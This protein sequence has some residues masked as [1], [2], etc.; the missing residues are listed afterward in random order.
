MDLILKFLEDDNPYYMFHW[1]YKELIEYT[2]EDASVI[3]SQILA[4]MDFLPQKEGHSQDVAGVIKKDEPI[5]FVIEYVKQENELPILVD[6]T[7][8]ELD[9]YLDYI[10][11]KKSI[12]SYIN[13][14]TTADNIRNSVLE[15]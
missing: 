6:L 8:I 7:V 3:I 10:V 9:E 1:F 11:D 4:V 2:M 5:F 13:E 14:Y 15:R 12:K